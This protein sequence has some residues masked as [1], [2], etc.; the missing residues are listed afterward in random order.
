LRKR[1]HRPSPALAISLI[2]LFVA[3][4]GTG[5][6]AVTIN[7][8]D[9]KNKS[10]AGKKLKNT[11]VGGGKI[12]SNAITGPKVKAGSLEATDF[13]AGQIPAGSQGP[14][15]DKGD[16]GATGPSEVIFDDGSNVSLTG[17]SRNTIATLNLPAGNWL[18]QAKT[19]MQ[20][21]NTGG[22][23]DCYIRTTVDVDSF[24]TVLDPNSGT[25]FVESMFG[26]AAVTLAVPTTVT[27]QCQD[28]GTGG[29]AIAA[30]PVMTA[31]RVGT[32][33]AQ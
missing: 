32:L 3:L 26:V 13:K 12:K 27:T 22:E 18:V 2:A 10:I 19:V 11:T 4:G 25:S 14:K 15:G 23:V 1:I 21:D 33:T 6:A 28:H 31:T 24:Y 20:Q 16:T 5:Y 30:S 29:G 7:G 17:G 8:K 9:I